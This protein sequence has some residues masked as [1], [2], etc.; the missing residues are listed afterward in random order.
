MRITKVRLR[1]RA[2]VIEYASE[3]ETHT[4]TS[5][6]NPLPSFVKAV[7][8]LKPLVL[9]ILHLPADYGDKM[10]T[11]GLTMAEK[12]EAELV[13]IV[14]QKELP[15]CHSPFNI[16]TP[17]RF[18]AHPE[19][20][21]SYSPALDDKDVA[22]VLDVL[23]EAKKYVKGDRAQGQLPLESPDGGDEEEGEAE[24]AQGDVLD[25]GKGKK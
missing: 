15:E 14:A 8:N 7:E 1:Q 16:A 13:T 11:T 2:V 19:E 5:R 4:L 3:K 9:S 18:L 23:E 25:F 6:D 10:K 24:P 12:Q 21:G 20:A 17:L 22:V